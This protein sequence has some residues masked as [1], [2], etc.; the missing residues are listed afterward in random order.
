MR[1]PAR[2]RRLGP[3]R[4][5]WLP[6]RLAGQ[7]VPAVTSKKPPPRWL[8]WWRRHS[9]LR[10]GAGCVTVYCGGPRDSSPRMARSPGKLHGE[11]A[12]FGAPDIEGSLA[13]AAPT[14][15]VNPSKGANRSE[16]HTSELQ[17]LR[18]LV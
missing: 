5:A 18:H 6:G 4:D 10:A 9:A 13:T 8:A 16:E 12:A 14:H 15:Q 17:S 7:E 11:L 3:R 1:G 2:R